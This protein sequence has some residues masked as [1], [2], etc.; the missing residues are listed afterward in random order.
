[1]LKILH[2]IPN[3]KKGGAERLVLNICNEIQKKNNITITLITFSAHNDYENISQEI[4]W[5]V[6]PSEFTPSISGKS[7]LNIIKLQKYISQHRPDIIHT[8]LWEAEILC[9]Q[10]NYGNAKSFTHFHDNIFQLKNTIIPLSKKEL[11]NL[12]ERKIVVNNY[13][14]RDHNFICISKNTFYFANKVLPKRFKHSINLLHNSV[15]LNDFIAPQRTASF[16]IKLINIGS[17]VP[18]KNQ[19]FAVDILLEIIKLGY[20]ANITF[21]GDGVLKKSISDYANKLNLSNNVHFKG[22]VN[23]VSQHLM[24]ANIYLHT[25]TW[26]PFGLVII[27]AMASS[28]PVISLDGKGNRDIIENNINGYIIKKQNSKLFADIIIELFNDKKQYETLS[29]ESLK[30]AKKF[31]IESYCNKLLALYYL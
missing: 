8:H 10:I 15:N 17:F 27:E 20:E 30:T 14:K 4:N 16:P 9:S 18:K 19:Q 6:I 29:E 25:A 31:D 22:N 7:V 1:M 11:T 12:Y 24:N 2:I 23:N 21:L 28:L 5:L 13:K 26:E 3:L